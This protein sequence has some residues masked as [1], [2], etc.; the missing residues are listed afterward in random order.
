MAP[1]L[2]GKKQDMLMEWK[3][4][5]CTPIEIHAKLLKVRGKRRGKQGGNER[6]VIIIIAS[7]AI[8]IIIINNDI[9]TTTI[10]IIAM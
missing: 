6:E 8:V 1:H 9:I 3:R 4:K 7:I 10:I 5:S 2:T